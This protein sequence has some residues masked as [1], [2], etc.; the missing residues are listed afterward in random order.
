[1]QETMKKRTGEKKRTL[2]SGIIRCDK[3]IA[4]VFIKSSTYHDFN[5]T[6]NIYVKF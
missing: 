1:M 4:I 2:L 6:I 3:K 5:H